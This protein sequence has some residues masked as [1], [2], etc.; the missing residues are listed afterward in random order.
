MFSIGVITDQVGMDF[1]EALQFIRDIGV[2]CIEIHALWNKNIEKL[3]DEEV[4]RV[5]RLVQK[6]GMKVSVVSS[7]LF[8]QCHLE[9]NGKEFESIDDYFITIVGSYD[10]QIA[11]LKRCIKLCRVFETDKI[12]AFGFL[13]EKSF[14]EHT[15]IQKVTEKLR[16]PVELVEETGGRTEGVRRT[17]QGLRNILNELGVRFT[18]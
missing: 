11:S 10:L 12:R 18:S 13:E 4:E 3:N 1:E 14:D 9:E 8:L 15:A 16:Y 2:G 17:Y 7:T 6:Y 5:V